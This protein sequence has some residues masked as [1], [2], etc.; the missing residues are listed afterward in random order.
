MK[1]L[2]VSFQTYEFV[3]YCAGMIIKEPQHE[4]SVMIVSKDD[5]RPILD[6]EQLCKSAVYEQRRDDL[7]NI[8]K[9]LKIKQAYN[10]GVEPD[11]IN[12]HKLV[13]QIQI[14]ILVGRIGEIYYNDHILLNRIFKTLSSKIPLY[15]YGDIV[16]EVSEKEYKLTIKEY[17]KKKQLTDFMIGVNSKKEKLYFSYT[18][19]FYKV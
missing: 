12:L 10:L 14:N 13:A 8:C 15:R 17:D 2:I 19:K 6:H 16:D 11:I 18:E 4:Y 3:K 1:R 7:F 9:F 5:R